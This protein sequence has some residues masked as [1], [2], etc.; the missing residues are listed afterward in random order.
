MR[1]AERSEAFGGRRSPVDRSGTD[2]SAGRRTGSDGSGK[3]APVRFAFGAAFRPVRALSLQ[4]PD[5]GSGRVADLMATSMGEFWVADPEAGALRVHAPDGTL[6]RILGREDTSLSRPVSLTGLHGRWIVALDGRKPR[7]AVLDEA[8]RLQ[9]RFPLPEVDRPVQ[10][11]NLADRWLVVAGDGW[12]AGA[13]KLIHV[14]T[15]FGDHVESLF[16][17]PNT[18]RAHGRA[19]IAAYGTSIYLAHTRSEVVSIYDTLARTVI[20][21]PA[22][23][24][25]DGPG[26]AGEPGAAADGRVTC[27]ELAGLFAT[28]CGEALTMY[29]AGGPDGGYVYDLNGL[30]GHPVARG[31]WTRERVVALEGPFFYSVAAATGSAGRVT[32]MSLRVWKLAYP[33]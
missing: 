3:P 20:A 22:S 7:L 25:G 15:L 23:G 6:I 14:Y 11:C 18:G 33:E 29:R 12:R 32:G 31:L 2:G 8:G 19:Y 13:G 4:A 10:V 9:R 21:F 5:R 27:D 16:S 30:G 1:G 28:R 17:V 26:G 24:D